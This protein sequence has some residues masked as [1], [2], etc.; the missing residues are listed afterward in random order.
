M[1]KCLHPVIF[2]ALWLLLIDSNSAVAQVRSEDSA[3]QRILPLP[4]GNLSNS[5][6][7][8]QLLQRLRSLV[9]AAKDSEKTDATPRDIPD[10][11]EKQLE[12]LQQALKKLQDLLPPGM[13]P[14]DLDSI[15][16]EQLDKAISNPAVQQQLKKMLEQFSEDGLLPQN[17]NGNSHPAMPPMPRQRGQAPGRPDSKHQSEPN[18]EQSHPP[19]EKSWQ[20]L[21]DAM[22]KLSQIAQGENHEA[23]ENEESRQRSMQAFQDLLERYKDS[24]GRIPEEDSS[25][26]VLRRPDRVTPTEPQLSPRPRMSELG[27]VFPPADMPS[28]SPSRVAQEPTDQRSRNQSD[29]GGKSGSSED[30]IPS[31]SEFLKDQLRKGFPVPNADSNT[32][33]E[34][35]LTPPV[36]NGREKP[37]PKNRVQQNQSVP[38]NSNLAA[39]ENEK[40]AIDIRQQLNER[41]LRGTIE[42]LVEK[43][44]EESNARHRAQQQEDAD[45]TRIGQAEHGG[46][47]SDGDIKSSESSTPGLQKSLTDLL[48][49]L[50]DNMPDILKDAK[51][52]DR[53]AESRR[54]PESA[55]R[56]LPRDSSSPDSESQLKKWNDAASGLL[57][58]LSQAPQAPASPDSASNGEASKDADSPLPIRSFF[59]TGLG[60]LG[61]LA[62]VAFGLR[63][64][65][66]KMVSEATGIAVTK[67]NGTPNE[68]R[69]REDVVSAFHALALNSRQHVESWWTHRAVARKLVAA[70][71]LKE[72]AVQTLAG[73]YEQ[74][75]YLPDD[76]ELPAGSI[77]SARSALAQ[78]R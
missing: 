23:L 41:G 53:P 7:Q 44:R 34:Q 2:A 70:S 43:A 1:S 52:K 47:Q 3:S 59:L 26:R 50:N 45:E 46:A 62:V 33:T 8:M 72:N 32:Q 19:S 36:V 77:E 65:L 31:V 57:S 39:S 11:D 15:P 21:K 63:R 28:R 37:S 66:L 22:K 55:G 54:K 74:A 30:S 4:D 48:G 56:S 78:C 27:E 24:G 14:P 64:P 60:L 10:V 75:R 42:K 73:L 67:R 16:E 13:M 5:E 29:G 61:L 68:I 58:D 49:G 12:Q 35:G 69:S 38:D 18:E 51:L 6:T 40:S 20:A 17:D 25:S 9:N 71:P 76:V